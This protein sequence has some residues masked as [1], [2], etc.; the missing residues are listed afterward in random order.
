MS[1]L[2][3]KGSQGTVS[4]GVKMFATKLAEQETGSLLLGHVFFNFNQEIHHFVLGP[5]SLT[6]SSLIII[7]C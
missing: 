1:V 2:D 6:A 3:F 7:P 4:E 5:L